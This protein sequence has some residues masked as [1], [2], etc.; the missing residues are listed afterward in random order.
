MAAGQRGTSQAECQNMAASQSRDWFRA[1]CRNC[2]ARRRGATGKHTAA[3]INAMSKEAGP[4]LILRRRVGKRLSCRSHCCAV[5]GGDNCTMK[6]LTAMPY[7]QRRKHAKTQDEFAFSMA[8]GFGTYPPCDVHGHISGIQ[9]FGR[10]IGLF[11][12]LRRSISR[13]PAM[14]IMTLARLLSAKS[15]S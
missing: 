4:A 13:W 7:L 3:E 2:A 12:D 5:R 6:I 1:S 10:D 14:A 8:V 9:I 15:T 11:C